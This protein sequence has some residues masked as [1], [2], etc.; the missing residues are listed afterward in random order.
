MAAGTTYSEAVSLDGLVQ[1]SNS[2][3]SP[4]SSSGKETT[5]F[6][7]PLLLCLGLLFLAIKMWMAGLAPY[8][9][10]YD[11]L[12]W[13]VSVKTVA[14]AV[15]FAASQFALLWMGWRVAGWPALLVLPPVTPFFNYGFHYLGGVLAHYFDFIRAF[16]TA[17]YKNLFAGLG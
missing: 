4:T 8:L 10:F 11:V 17:V 5:P 15:L 13:Q 3:F 2:G 14:I 16:E 7:G 9:W 6:I 1:S 12:N